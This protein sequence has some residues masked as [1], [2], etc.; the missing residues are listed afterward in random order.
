MEG[1]LI[2]VLA[3]TIISNY[4]IKTKYANTDLKDNLDKLKSMKENI[5]VIENKC[6]IYDKTIDSLTRC[7]DCKGSN[8]GK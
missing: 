5:N 8:N 1:F 3:T 4:M 6:S 2:S 7:I